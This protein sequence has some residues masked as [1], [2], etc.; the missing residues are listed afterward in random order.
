[1]ETVRDLS[2]YLG[3]QTY[4]FNG[5]LPPGGSDGSGAPGIDYQVP[6]EALTG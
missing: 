5:G 2:G 3:W 1:M 6:A 4:L